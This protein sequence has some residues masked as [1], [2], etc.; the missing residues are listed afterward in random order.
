M[1]CDEQRDAR[2]WGR[3]VCPCWNMP[4]DAGEVF[5]AAEAPRLTL[6][7]ENELS[8]LGRSFANTLEIMA[9]TTEKAGIGRAET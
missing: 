2:Q 8:H 9:S 6:C 1:G 5:R 4:W 3:K 7:P